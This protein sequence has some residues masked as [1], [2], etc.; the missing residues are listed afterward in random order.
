MHQTLCQ[1][2]KKVWLS[3]QVVEEGYDCNFI[4][5]KLYKDKNCKNMHELSPGLTVEG[6]KYMCKLQCQQLLC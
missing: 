4:S 3:K 2:I 1:I 6:S 5:E